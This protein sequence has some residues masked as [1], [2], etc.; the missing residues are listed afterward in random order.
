MPE[1]GRDGA[2][3]A[4]QDRHVFVVRIWREPRE[5]PGAAAEWRGVIEHLPTQEHRYLTDLRAIG[6]FIAP[7]LDSMGVAQARRGRWS[8]WLQ[9]RPR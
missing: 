8:R 3:S 2:H 1:D 7:Y 4:D 6:R 5:M 9:R